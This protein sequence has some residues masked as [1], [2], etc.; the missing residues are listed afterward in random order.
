MPAPVPP[1]RR[2]SKSLRTADSPINEFI[3]KALATPGLISFAAGLVDEESLPCAAVQAAMTA[4]LT[5]PQRGRA[6][7]QYG[8]TQGW[9]PLRQQVLEM[10]GDADGVDP[11]A[12][13][14]SPQDV[15]ITTGSQQLLYLLAELLL[16]PG[17]IVITESPS[18]FVFHSVLHSHG[19]RVL[20]VPMD[21]GGLQL[22]RLQHLLDQLD[23][24]R[25]LDRVKLIYTVDYFQNPTGITL[26]AER[27][28]RLVELARRYSR[29]HRLLIVEDAAYRELRYDGEDLPSIKSHDRDNQFVVYCGTFSK[30][31][32][33]GLKTGY[34]IVPADVREPLL[35]LKGNHDFGSAH[36]LQVALAELV[37]SGA[38]AAQV[39]RLRQV[40][41]RKRDR[42]L[43]ELERC[44]G[45][46]PGVRWIRP[47]GGLYVWLTFDELE[48]GPD[49]PLAAAALAEG[50]LYVPGQL[51]EPATDSDTDEDT[52]ASWDVGVGMV[53]DADADVV[54]GAVA[55]VGI[56]ADADTDAAPAPTARLNGT[57]PYAKQGFAT[58]GLPRPHRPLGMRNLGDCRRA[59]RLS[60]G[61][62]TET[63][64]VEG[65]RRFRRA[66]DRVRAA[67]TPRAGTF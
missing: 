65:V 64:I 48:T 31:C 40:Y 50:V 52:A 29:T 12:A 2:S 59:C 13:G 41:R 7:L 33:P 32:A 36:L 19:V 11:A 3:H 43:E 24:N 10:L 17:D 35:H 60:F 49:S 30:P 38:Y 63:E 34:A 15:V 27:R 37:A 54:A 39:A 45:D 1:L 42:M 55:E 5:D 46:L 26:A 51:A 62:A 58:N 53:A 14:L 47:A 21:V 28:P 56:A 61:V 22:D 18:Y 6:A 66:V 25:K 67:A 9:P 57:Q 44:F 23:R 16:D 4:V 20:G 8:S